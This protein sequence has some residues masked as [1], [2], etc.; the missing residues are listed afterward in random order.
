MSLV[1][2]LL[3]AVA[4]IAL[5]TPALADDTA[6]QALAPRDARDRARGFEW[7]VQ[8]NTDPDSCRHGGDTGIEETPDEFVTGW[9]KAFGDDAAATEDQGTSVRTSWRELDGQWYSAF[10]FKGREACEA[11]ASSKR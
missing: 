6:A 7:W 4:L 3:A 10:W 1:T 11:A 2:K 5:A 9:R 8:L